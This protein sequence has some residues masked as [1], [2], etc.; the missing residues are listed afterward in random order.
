MDSEREDKREEIRFSFFFGMRKTKKKILGEK[1]KEIEMKEK[2]KKKY[3]L[4]VV[5]YEK[6]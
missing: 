4:F 6:K 1:M 3:I 2:R 5:W